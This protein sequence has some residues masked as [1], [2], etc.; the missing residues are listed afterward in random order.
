MGAR[1][2]RKSLKRQARPAGDDDVGRV[3]DEGGGSAD[4]GGHRLGDQERHRRQTEPV[5]HQQRH[6]GDEQH[7]G[8]VVQ[9]GRGDRR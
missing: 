1:W 2:A 8:D 6:R 7:R 5:A 9:Q 4:V 3:A